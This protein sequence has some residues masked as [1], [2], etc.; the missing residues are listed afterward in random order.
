MKFKTITLEHAE[1]EAKR[2]AARVGRGWKVAWDA[3]ADGN[4]HNFHITNGT[5]PGIPLN[6]CTPKGLTVVL[7]KYV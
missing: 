7:D 4:P 2:F 1:R 3:D 5:P 6:V